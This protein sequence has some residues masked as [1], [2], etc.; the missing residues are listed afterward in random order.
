MEIISQ[1]EVQEN[2]P[3]NLLIPALREAFKT[4]RIE[5]PLRHHHFF[6]GVSGKEVSTLLLMPAWQTNQDVGVKVV[7][8]S[9]HN[10]K[11]QLPSIQGVY[12]LLDAVTGQPKALIDAPS[13]TAKRTAA[14]SA[15]AASFLSREDSRTLLMIGTGVLAPELIQA[16][17]SIRPIEKVYIWGRSYEKAKKIAHTL[18]DK[19]TASIEPIEDYTTIISDV[20]IV[21]CATL[22]STPLVFGEQLREGQH[23]DLVG[24]YKPN[25]READNAVLWQSS[26]FVDTLEGASKETGDLAIP[27]A[28]G[29]ITP[30]DILAELTTLCKGEHMGRTSSKEITVF[31]SVGHAL[32]DLVAAQLITKQLG[33]SPAT[34]HAINQH[35]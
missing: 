15:L 7:T 12:F 20:D 11:F 1:R 3:F 29:S 23:I 28:E 4:Q 24:A 27:L 22:S 6:Q 19:I 8:V 10:S 9:P 33:I 26:I 25:M 35:E 5:V 2:L 13:L 17:C 14:A 34:N 21:S 31:K 16:H 32:E 30:N 18:E